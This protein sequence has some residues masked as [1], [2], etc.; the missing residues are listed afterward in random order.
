MLFDVMEAMYIV[1]EKRNA[2]LQTLS[3]IKRIKLFIKEHGDLFNKVKKECVA[4]IGAS[5]VKV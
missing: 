1:S 2:D 3:N 5:S 4:S